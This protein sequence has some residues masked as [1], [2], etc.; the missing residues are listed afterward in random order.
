MANFEPCCHI[1]IIRIRCICMSRRPTRKHARHP[2]NRQH[3]T[4]RLSDSQQERP[5]QNDLYSLNMAYNYRITLTFL[6]LLLK[7]R[8]SK[9]R[10]S[11]VLSHSARSRA[12]TGS[13]LHLRRSRIL[14]SGD[15]A[16]MGLE[17]MTPWI[18]ITWDNH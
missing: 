3:H 2:G 13:C 4:I 14:R 1:R 12:R 7:W 15:G 18:G 9:A 6:M 17:E 5:S 11:E 10:Q 16:G 8:F